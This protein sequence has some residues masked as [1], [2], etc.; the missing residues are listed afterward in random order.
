MKRIDIIYG[1]HSYSVGGRELD[2]I[3][4]E[5]V[6]GLA[7]GHHWL[8][9]NDGEGMKRDAFLLITPGSNVSLV[10]IPSEVPGFEH[11]LTP[12]AQP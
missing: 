10:P 11:D 3:Q 8:K 4:N 2:E 9:V 5:I 12:P 6:T 1:G 7:N